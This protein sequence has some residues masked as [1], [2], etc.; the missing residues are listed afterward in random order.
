MK[1]YLL[2]LLMAL[3]MAAGIPTVAGASCSIPASDTGTQLVNDINACLSS[4]SAAGLPSGA[5]EGQFLGQGATAPAWYSMSGDLS[6]STTSPGACTVVGLRGMALRNTAPTNGQVPQFNSTNGDVEWST[7]TGVLPTG[8][9]E[10]QFLLEGS[11][12]PGWFTLGGDITGSTTSPGQMTVA[13]VL[14]GQTPV[15]IYG[16]S[17]G[18]LAFEN[19]S[20]NGYAWLDFSGDIANSTT[21]P[22]AITVTGLRGIPITSSAPTN[23]YVLAYNSTAANLQWV[24]QGG[25]TSLPSGATAGQFLLE[26]A[27]ATSAVWT[28]LSGDVSNSTGTPGS[29]TVNTVKSGQ[30]PTTMQG[31]SAG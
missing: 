14:N 17:A 11:A 12:S 3:A 19:A 10:G 29:L 26:N 16:A 28:T 4:V 31:A 18:S 24:A 7:V 9:T 5:T 8:A 23:G 13:S 25:G 21:S 6:C 2:V 1:Q 22:A 30:T 27:G 20:A 15:T